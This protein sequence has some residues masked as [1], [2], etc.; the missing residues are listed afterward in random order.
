MISENFIPA[1]IIVNEKPHV[2]AMFFFNISLKLRHFI[3][4]AQI[5][6]NGVLETILQKVNTSSIFFIDISGQFYL[7]F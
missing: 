7:S 6:C 5:R 4:Y 3:N 2:H 1:I